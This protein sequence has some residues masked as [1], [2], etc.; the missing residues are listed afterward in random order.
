MARC[1]FV[2]FVSW[3]CV[4]RMRYRTSNRLSKHSIQIQEWGFSFKL[5]Q[6]VKS[7]KKTQKKSLH[8]L[9]ICI[10]Y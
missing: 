3:L 8:C 10:L 5:D 2:S 1:H 9:K 7:D 4:G 6:F